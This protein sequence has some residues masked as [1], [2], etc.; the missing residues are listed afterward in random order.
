MAYNYDGLRELLAVLNYDY[1]NRRMR[2]DLYYINPGKVQRYYTGIWD[3]RT[4]KQ[5]MIFHRIKDYPLPSPHGCMI[6]PTVGGMLHP[7]LVERE[8]LW[9]GKGETVVDASVGH[10]NKQ[11]NNS[12]GEKFKKVVR[13]PTNHWYVAWGND[14]WNYFESTA[15]RKPIRLERHQKNVDNISFTLKRVLIQC[16]RPVPARNSCI[17]K[18]Y[19]NWLLTVGV[20]AFLKLRREVEDRVVA[21]TSVLGEVAV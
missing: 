16:I 13:V 3:Y 9:M 14:D 10:G 12:T 11:S 6:V 8:G 1:P 18:V 2:Q 20:G 5:Y 19:T 21:G 15:S 17:N 7:R 4:G